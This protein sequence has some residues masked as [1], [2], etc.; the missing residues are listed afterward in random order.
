MYTPALE[1]LDF[2]KT[3]ALPSLRVVPNYSHEAQALRYGRPPN[4][5]ATPPVSGPAGGQ[6]AANFMANMAE[7]N[8]HAATAASGQLGPLATEP[9]PLD[10]I[11]RATP[12]RHTRDPLT[13]DHGSIEHWG[14]LNNK[15]LPMGFRD[16][17]QSANR[18]TG[19]QHLESVLRAHAADISP[20][21]AAARESGAVPSHSGGTPTGLN[22][23]PWGE[24]WATPFTTH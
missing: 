23:T 19:E 3:A 15:T 14:T 2:R 17:V 16:T 18:H 7:Q 5:P 20:A 6:H 10:N 9:H 12:Q 22:Y 1:I 11:D 13:A 8:L 24:H 21:Y 4:Y